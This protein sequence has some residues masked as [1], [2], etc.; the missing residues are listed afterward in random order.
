M[1]LDGRIQRL[2]DIMRDGTER[3]AKTGDLIMRVQRI[4]VEGVAQAERPGQCASHFPGVLRVDIEIEKVERLICV[5]RERLRRGVRDSI[6]KLLQ[7]RVGHGGNRAFS[8]VIVVQAEDAGIG[9]KPQLV[10]AAAPG[11]IVVDEKARGAPALNPG[12]VQPSD[13]REG[14]CAGALQHD[15]KRGKR[16]L[17]VAR[18]KQA[19]IPGECGIEVV[20]QVLREHVRVSCREGVERLRGNRIEQRVDGVGVGSLHARVGLKTKPGRIFLD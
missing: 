20:H 11:K 5:R 16:L 12:I 8:E 6:D 19:F 18:P 13:G 1:S 14:I 7:V 9:S 10:S 3:A 17:K 4:G 2:I 15:R